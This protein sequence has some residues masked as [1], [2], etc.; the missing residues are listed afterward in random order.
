MIEL[1]RTGCY[2]EFD[3]FGQESS[4][5]ALNPEA[6]RPN[7]ATRV[8]WLIA[9]IEAGYEDRLLVA[10]D[11]CQKVYLRRYGGPGYTHILEQAIPLMRRRGMSDDQIE[12]L[13]VTNPSTIL[14]LG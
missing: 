14:A 8:D 12:A 10:Q 13:T 11:I 4:Y 2:L 1:A 6:N 9:L 3:L 7:D 5:Y